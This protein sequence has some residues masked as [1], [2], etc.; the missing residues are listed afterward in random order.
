MPQLSKVASTVFEDNQGAVSLAN[1]PKMN[2]RTK[3][4]AVKYHLFCSH[5]EQG[6]IEVSW[7]KGDDQKADLLTK[8]LG[9]VKFVGLRKKALGW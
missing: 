8:G 2:P 1:T 9:A 7:I 5:I 6:D 3:H 4:I